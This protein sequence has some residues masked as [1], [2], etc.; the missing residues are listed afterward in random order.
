M[1]VLVIDIGGSSLKVLAT[2]QTGPR[3]CPSGPTLTPRQMVSAVVKL[4]EDWR[5]DAVSIGLPAR[6]RRDR[7]VSEPVN[8]GPGWVDFDFAK[9]FGRPVK[10]IN[11]AA[12]QA[13]G[14]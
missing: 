11:D 1:K 8:L 7:V 5:Y 10:V 12:M 14:S 3:E 4:T 2:G 6:V 13:L 9:A